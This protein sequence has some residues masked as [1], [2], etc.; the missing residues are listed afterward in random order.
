[1][2]SRIIVGLLAFCVFTCLFAAAGLIPTAVIVL[3]CWLIG[4]SGLA[5]AAFGVCVGIN[6]LLSSVFGVASALSYED[7]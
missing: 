5:Q 3:L 2:F 6:L 7:Y 4:G 1:M